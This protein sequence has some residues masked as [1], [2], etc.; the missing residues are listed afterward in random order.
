MKRK[1]LLASGLMS[2]ILAATGASPAM[3]IQLAP[4]KICAYEN[5][6]RCTDWYPNL[7]TCHNIANKPGVT[8]YQLRACLAWSAYGGRG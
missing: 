2:A 8:D 4:Q 3:A 5:N 7:Y 6:G 1:T